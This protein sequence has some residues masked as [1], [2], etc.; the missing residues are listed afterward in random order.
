MQRIDIKETNK[1][2]E[3][4]NITEDKD[5]LVFKAAVIL[6]YGVSNNTCC[7]QRLKRATGYWWKEVGF[8]VNNFWASGIIKEYRWDF[9]LSEDDLNSLL[10]ITC[11][12]MAGA[13]ELRAQGREVGK[14]E[15]A[16]SWEEYMRLDFKKVKEPHLKIA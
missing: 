8:I 4:L 15:I 5:S 7:T 1:I 10:E 16:Y 9:F 13:G 11:C 2:V 14:D 12:A 6:L 3:Q